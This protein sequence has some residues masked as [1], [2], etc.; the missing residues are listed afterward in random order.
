MEEQLELNS[1]QLMIMVTCC[2]LITAV[3]SILRIHIHIYGQ[4]KE[5]KSWHEGKERFGVL[6]ISLPEFKKKY[7]YKMSIDSFET[8]TDK[9]QVGVGNKIWT[10]Q[11]RSN[12]QFGSSCV[13]YEVRT[14]FYTFY[15][16]E[17]EWWRLWWRRT[18][19]K[20]KMLVLK[21][22]RKGTVCIIEYKFQDNI[23]IYIFL[24]CCAVHFDNI[25]ILFTNECTIY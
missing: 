18:K 20:P 25:K 9:K 14:H 15:N 19:H 16:G 6:H 17:I 13:L 1:L 12:K 4:N 5:E 24:Y 2:V 21:P 23:E 7:W 11:R 8:L 10:Q 22:W 3:G